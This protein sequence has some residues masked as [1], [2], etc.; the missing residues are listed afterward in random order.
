MSAR[1]VP[2]ALAVVL[3]SAR[4]A[5]QEP[6]R[7]LEELEP[8]ERPAELVEPAGEPDAP[9]QAS[10]ENV[11]IERNRS[12]IH[13]GSPLSISGNE[14]GEN[15]LRSRT[16][17]LQNVVQRAK[18][19]DAGALHE[20]ALAAYG[21]R[22]LFAAPPAGVPKAPQTKPRGARSAVRS[23]VLPE[24]VSPWPVVGGMSVGALVL[25]WLVARPRVRRAAS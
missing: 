2:L 17:A 21:D 16:P 10:V 9:S 14:Q 23:G 1:L 25:A 19:V 22:A 5:A 15:D 12:A 24:G 11:L 7:P 13:P 6:P 4:A 20:R 3:A 18:E 8:G